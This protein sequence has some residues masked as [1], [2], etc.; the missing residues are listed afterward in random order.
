MT[1]I[2]IISKLLEITKPIKNTMKHYFCCIR[3]ET[4]VVTKDS[5]STTFN[6]VS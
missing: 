6:Y 5:L 3:S 1:M 2:F 4:L